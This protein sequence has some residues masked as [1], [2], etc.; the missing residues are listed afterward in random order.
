MTSPDY[1]RLQTIAE[2]AVDMATRRLA[3]YAADRVETRFKLSGEEVTDADLSVQ[4]EIG[5]FLRHGTPDI[6]FIGEESDVPQAVTRTA[7]VF[8]PIDG[9]VNFSRG[10][11]HYAISL[12]LVH[13]FAPVI[14]V[15]CAPRL[16]VRIAASTASGPTRVPLAV[17][18]PRA[19]V[20]VAGMG[21]SR[22]AAGADVIRDLHTSAYRVRSYGSMCL[23]VVGVALGWLDGCVCI[24]PRPWDVAAGIAIVRAHGYLAIGPGGAD[25]TWSS[26][27]L[28]VG[29][30][31]LIRD[32]VGIVAGRI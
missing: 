3:N 32:I 5:R 15:V 17:P 13:D 18:L 14:G 20:G 2:Q 30:P 16:G 19:I 25:F 9:T 21:G 10:A 11:P 12:A 31:P 24:R 28:A 23:T 8:D 4:D 27:L 6:P 26:P 1:A 29:T 22:S 7:W